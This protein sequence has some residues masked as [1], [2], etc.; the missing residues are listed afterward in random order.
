MAK[1]EKTLSK[2]SSGRLDLLMI[3]VTLG[4]QDKSFT[5]L[6]DAIQKAIDDGTI[7]EEV[8]V[9]AGYTKYE[10][11]DMKIFDLI[12][13]DEFDKLV[14]KCRILIT[15]GGVGSIMT[16]LKAGKVVIAAPRLS[17][18]K[19]HT[20]DHQKEIIREFAKEGYLVELKDFNQ[21]N[22][23]LTYAKKFK[24]KK[25]E[26]NTQ[27]FIALI[28]NYIEE[29][30][31]KKEKKT[32]ISLKELYQ[33]Y[34]EVIMYLIFGVLTTLVSLAIYYGLVFTIIDPSDGVMLQV[35][36]FISWFGALIFA[37]V[38]N[39]KFVFQSHEQNK[40]KEALSFAG[41]RLV[42]LFMDMAIMFVGVTVMHGNDK[43]MK[44]ISQVVVI[45]ANYV[46]SKI[47][48]FRKK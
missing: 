41:A 33:K 5:R 18:Y 30:S 42:T 19:E 2:S 1:Y 8:I 31:M 12:P 7:K 47:F 21:L 22:K 36:N 38:T 35:A 46:F 20:N 24:P 4:T 48:V 10:S 39:R 45:V 17:K 26:S 28:E 27:N 9:Q 6:L 34:R 3:L 23:T 37:Y 44:L 14:K 29:D 43:I 15:H 40:M 32:K 16:G 13:S 11:K 25:F